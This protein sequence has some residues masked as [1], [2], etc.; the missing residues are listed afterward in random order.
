[1]CNIMDEA[2]NRHIISAKQGDGTRIYI[3]HSKIVSRKLFP[4]IMGLVIGRTKHCCIKI[5]LSITKSSVIVLFVITFLSIAS[6][7]S[8]R[9]LF[10]TSPERI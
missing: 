5:P 1:M 8:N 3:Q 9:S 10:H 6:I 2:D 4:N 7:T